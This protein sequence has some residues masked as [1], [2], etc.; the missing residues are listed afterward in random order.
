M[1]GTTTG[2]SQQHLGWH[3]QGVSF[4]VQWRFLQPPPQQNTPSRIS[5]VYQNGQWWHEM[6]LAGGCPWGHPVVWHLMHSHWFW[7]GVIPDIMRRGRGVWREMPPDNARPVCIDST[8]SNLFQSLNVSAQETIT[9]LCNKNRQSGILDWRPFVIDVTSLRFCG[10]K[11]IDVFSAD[12]RRVLSLGATPVRQV[13]VLSRKDTTTATWK[14]SASR[15]P[16][17]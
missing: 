2:M 10:R 6:T 8:T 5:W 3:H 11:D 15:Q 7:Q 4:M 16:P 14:W 17:W 13:R 12:I 9:V 1:S